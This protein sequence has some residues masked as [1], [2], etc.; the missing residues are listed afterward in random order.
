[1]PWLG[2][3]GIVLPLPADQNQVSYYGYG[4]GGCY[5]DM[6]HSAYLDRFQ[7]TVQEMGDD[8]IKPQETG[9]RW[10]CWE[11]QV[12]SVKV[13]GKKPFSFNASPYS[14][15][16]LTKTRH[17]YELPEPKAT[18]FHIDYKMSGVGSNSCG[19]TLYEP[20]RFSEEKFQWEFVLEI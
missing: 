3:F 9:S 20:Y 10:H 14:V 6:H 4:P 18:W 13:T 7:T 17:N 19:P 16:E 8:L 1:M 11:A 2:R 12:G 15:A 5:E